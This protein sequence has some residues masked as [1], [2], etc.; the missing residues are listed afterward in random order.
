MMDTT[1]RIVLRVLSS[2]KWYE[3]ISMYGSIAQLVAGLRFLVA[4]REFSR[5]MTGVHDTF[6]MQRG[7]EYKMLLFHLEELS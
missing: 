6:A 2:R 7:I 3:S 1:S 4:Y 5:T